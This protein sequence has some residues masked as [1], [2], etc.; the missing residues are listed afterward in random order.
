[1]K[2]I[3]FITLIGLVLLSCSDDKKN[4]KN[5]NFIPPMQIEISDEIKGDTELVDLVKSSEKAINEF[6]NNIEQIAID[7]KDVLHK[8]FNIEEASFT[9]KIQVGKLLLEFG[10]NSTQM[11]AT[12]QKYSSYIE[13][14]QKTGELNKNQLKALEQVSEALQNRINKI[15]KKY[16]HYFE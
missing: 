4:T 10:S 11:I 7:G 16:Q 8:D 2:K 15:N 3:L 9:E 12:M 5:A 14:K 1:M 6:S 13:E